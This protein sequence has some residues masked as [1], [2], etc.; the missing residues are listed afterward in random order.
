MDTG[1]KG[2]GWDEM[3]VCFGV[4]PSSPDS[5]QIFPTLILCKAGVVSASALSHKGRSTSHPHRTLL[6]SSERNSVLSPTMNPT[7]WSTVTQPSVASRHW[8]H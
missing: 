4:G 6:L 7:L 3:R 2:A 8:G 5:R 1:G